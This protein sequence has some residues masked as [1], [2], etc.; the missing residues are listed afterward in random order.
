MT[1]RGCSVKRNT[2]AR[3]PLMPVNPAQTNIQL[4]ETVAFPENRATRS[5]TDNPASAKVL[6]PKNQA[7][8]RRNNRYSVGFGGTMCGEELMVRDA[9]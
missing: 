4:G 9:G 5:R 1:W 6:Q 3:I 7:L 8:L 2:S